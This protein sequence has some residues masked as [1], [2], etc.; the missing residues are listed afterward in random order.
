MNEK[1]FDDIRIAKGYA[2][3]P[4]LHK[5]AIERVYEDTGRS[6]FCNGLDVGCGAGLS[7]KALKLICNHVTG[8]DI[9]P[10]MV[11]ACKILYPQKDFS[12]FVNSGDKNR[13]PEK[14]YDIVTAAGMINWV[15]R[16]SF[17]ENM[18]N[19]MSKNGLL[20]IYD[21]G[22]TDRMCDTAEYTKWYRE[23]YLKN[24]PKPFR[25]E[26]IWT[27]ADVGKCFHIIKQISYEM[28]YSFSL[29]NFVEFM[30]IQSNVNEKINDGQISEQQAKAW[31][32]E[33][34]EPIF[35]DLNRTLIFKG[36]SWYLCK[37]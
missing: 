31:L 37:A 30:S 26:N 17:L 5:K 29:E 12:F 23:T 1:S 25:K 6:G 14:P 3:R 18:N 2:N 32:R 34:L 35:K 7:T 36:Y 27:Q 20:L 13:L 11:D 8:T 19:I 21:F 10:A 22:I 9:S 33:T 24:F 4:W 28:T 15:D 16:E